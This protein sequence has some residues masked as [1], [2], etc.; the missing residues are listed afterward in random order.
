MFRSVSLLM[1]LWSL[2]LAPVLCL[3]GVLEHDCEPGGAEC[4]E[5]CGPGDDCASSNGCEHESACHS[6]PCSANVRPQ[7]DSLSVDELFA[8]SPVTWLPA[9]H[10]AL[11]PASPLSRA[12][13]GI[14]SSDIATRPHAAI[15][16]PLLI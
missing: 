6:D 14:R 11:S 3:G 13:F 15:L 7:E 2:V 12:D 4:C 10:G 8:A 16:L 1:V 9:M 5:T